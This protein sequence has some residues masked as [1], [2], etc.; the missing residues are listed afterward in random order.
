MY[1]SLVL[2]LAVGCAVD[3]N[4]NKEPDEP[5]FDP[6]DTGGLPDTDTTDT[7]PPPAEECNGLDDDGDGTVDEDFADDDGNGRADCMD[8]E[9]PALDL[10]SAGT[11]SIVEECAGTTSEVVTDPWNAVIEYQYTSAGM[12]VIVMPAVGNLNDDNGDGRVD[13]DDVPEIVFTSWGGNTLVALDGATG[14]ELFEVSGYDG[15]GGVTIA[16]VDSDGDPEIVAIQTGGRIAAVDETGTAEWTSASFGMMSYPQPT[17]ADL[18]ND[19]MPEVIGDVGVVNGED[20]STVATLS[21]ITN[22]W[23]TPVAADLDQDGD[24]E[25]IL[26]NKVFDANGSTVWSNSGNGS[27]NFSAV[28]DADGDP[29]AEV[30]FVSNQTAYLHEDDGTLITS[31]A[32]PGGT[33]PGPPCAADFDGDGEVELAVPNST[34]ISV[35]DMDGT[36][37]WSNVMQDNSGLAG[38]SGYDVNGDGAYEV[39]FADEIA[40]RIYDGTDGTILYENTNHGSGTVWEY[41]VTA[42]VDNDGS[43][44]IVVA[45]NGGTWKGVT[46]FGHAG[47]GWPKSGTTWATHDFAVTNIEPDGSVPS[48]PDPS[49]QV[50]NVFRARP[51]VDD[52]SSADLLVEITDI[53]VADCDYGPIKLSFQVTNQ[54][55][56]EVDAGTLVSVYADDGTLRFLTA[57]ALPEVP[58]GAMLEGIEVELGPG[59]VGDFGFV[60]RVDD[61]GAGG[62]TVR[63]CDETNNEDDYSDVFCF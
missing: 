20:G 55:G 49:W 45:D 54:G 30:F 24:Q 1:R 44:E 60:V 2:L 48:P 16:D 25:I 19:G 15:Q 6:G 9:C 51:S 46:V 40:F 58:A 13:E 53:C 14:A 27:G 4:I 56:A 52:P 61:D 21:G 62:E 38:C 32:I 8:V 28:V 11:V 7:D 63:E 57:V 35:F 18:D 3:N 26:G 42:D 10:G 36:S 31:F 12:G 43:A 23:R 41:P 34:R 50:Y 47:D 29:E 59:D 37:L 22:S 17:V 5:H 39:L 33:I